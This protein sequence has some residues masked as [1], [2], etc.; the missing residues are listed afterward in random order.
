MDEG[1]FQSANRY[2][3]Q[4]LFESTESVFEDHEVGHHVVRQRSDEIST[5]LAGLDEVVVRAG[6]VVGR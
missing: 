5:F 2:R 1:R 6:V 4:V 3:L